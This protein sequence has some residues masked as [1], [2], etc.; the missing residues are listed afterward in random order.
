M[1]R[2]ISLEVNLYR[3]KVL[4]VHKPS[5]RHKNKRGWGCGEVVP[6]CSVTQETDALLKKL[7]NDKHCQLLRRKVT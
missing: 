4:R 5:A 3:K 6:P 2:Q 7:A 1:R